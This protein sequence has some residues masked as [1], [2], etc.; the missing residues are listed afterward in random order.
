MRKA[1]NKKPPKANN[2]ITLAYWPRASQQ[3]GTSSIAF[4]HITLNLQ[5]HNLGLLATLREQPSTT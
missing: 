4:N 5:P 1:I 2:Q 3:S